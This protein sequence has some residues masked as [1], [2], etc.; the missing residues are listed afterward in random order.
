MTNT[1]NTPFDDLRDGSKH[2]SVTVMD[3]DLAL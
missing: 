3:Y 2:K 1:R